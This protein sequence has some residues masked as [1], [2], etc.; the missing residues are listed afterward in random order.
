MRDLHKLGNGLSASTEVIRSRIQDEQLRKMPEVEYFA[1][2]S[3]GG[4]TNLLIRW[5]EKGMEGTHQ[6]YAEVV[7]SAIIKVISGR[8]KR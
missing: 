4:F 1:T 6:E 2:Y 3:V 7:S 5:I 8:E